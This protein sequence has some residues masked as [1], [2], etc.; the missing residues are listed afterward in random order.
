MTKNV[1]D[2]RRIHYGW[3]HRLVATLSR[4]VNFTYTMRHGLAAGMKRRGGLGFIPWGSETAETGLLRG[5]DLAGRVVYDIG[6]FEGILTLFFSRRAA[7][8]VAYEPNP[9]SRARLETNLRLNRVANVRLR[10]VGLAD[11]YREIEL[12]YDPLMPGAASGGGLVAQQIR[13]DAP[14]TVEVK[15]T[16]VGL[17]DDIREQRLPLPDLLKVDVEGMELSV[18]RG[19]EETLTQHRPAIFLELHGAEVADKQRNAGDVVS[20]L[21]ACGYHNLLDVEAG[22]A[23]TPENHGRPSHLYCRYGAE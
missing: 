14:A 4:H 6:A 11:S 16:V 23:V 20:F 9:A 2:Y 21:W 12:V 18:L 15:A 1:H 5:L 19:A 8:V 17:D 7:Q 22:R 10:D 3:K 13:D